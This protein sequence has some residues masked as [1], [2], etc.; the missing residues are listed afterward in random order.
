[1]FSPA[2][3]VH[4]LGQIEVRYAAFFVGLDITRRNE[5]HSAIVIGFMENLS[6]INLLFTKTNEHKE[7]LHSDYTNDSLQLREDTPLPRTAR[8]DPSEHSRVQASQS[9]S[10]RGRTNWLLRDK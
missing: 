6:T 1:M 5:Y 2:F 4:E 7:D 8:H 9:L 10:D 3:Q